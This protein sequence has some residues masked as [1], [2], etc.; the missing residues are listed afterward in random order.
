M[1]RF[2]DPGVRRA[3]RSDATALAGLS[4]ELGYPATPAQMDERLACLYSREGH[5]VL[6]ADVGGAVSGWVHVCLVGSLESEPFAEIRGLVVTAERRSLGIGS[7]LVSAAEAWART[8]G[9]SRVR[10]RTN[11]VRTRTHGFYEKRGYATTKT[12]KVFEKRL[13]EASDSH[14]SRGSSPGGVGAMIPPTGGP[15]HRPGP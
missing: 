11:T 8:R 14:D 9:C 4:A 6:V 5:E 7:A 15:A 1:N 13:Q 2:Q 12:Q 3:A 10:V